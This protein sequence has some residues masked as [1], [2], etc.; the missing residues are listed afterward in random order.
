MLTITNGINTLVVT[1]GAYTSMYAPQGWKN[2]TSHSD[3]LEDPQT[4]FSKKNKTN[5]AIVEN[6]HT[7][8]PGI[9]EETTTNEDNDGVDFSEIPLSEMS[10]SQLKQYG[11]QLG[12]EINTDS[13]K[14]LR[15]RIKKVLE[16]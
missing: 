8:D 14:T 13:A 9:P 6:V 4:T 15:N 11:E 16:K 2:V 3:I 12:I 5:Q 7:D 10:V 1:K